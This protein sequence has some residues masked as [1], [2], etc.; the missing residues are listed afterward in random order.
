M[1][2]L[3]QKIKKLRTDNE[4]TLEQL[5]TE[6]GSTKS[7]VWKLENRTPKNPSTT[8][9]KKIAHIFGI[10]LSGLL[11]ENDQLNEQTQDLNQLINIY[12][13]FD[14]EKKLMVKKFIQALK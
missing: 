13:K 7:Y 1:D 6:I 4:M 3:G 8:K 2:L 14:P 5:A 9:L 11:G 12:Q 10:T